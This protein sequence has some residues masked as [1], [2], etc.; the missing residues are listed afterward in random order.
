MSD[1]DSDFF[2][3][4][5]HYA[6]D[7]DALMQ[8]RH[9][10][11]VDEQNVPPELEPDEHDATAT[12]VL[13]LSS[14]EQKPIGTARVVYLDQPN[15][16]KTAKIGRMA[17]LQAWRG[18][19]VG[20][21]MM[22]LL[23]DDARRQGAT[24]AELDA[25][26]HAMPFYESFGFTAHGDVFDDAGI[27]HKKMTT[28]LEP[29]DTSPPTSQTAARETATSQAITN[30]QARNQALHRIIERSTRHLNIFIRSLEPGLLDDEQSLSLIRQFVTANHEAHCRV[31]LREPQQAIQTDHPLIALMQRLPSKITIKQT[32][33]DV[34][35]T[36]HLDVYLNDRQD[37]LI[38]VQSERM[39]AKHHSA[40]P[41]TVKPYLDRFG[42][43][44]EHGIDIPDIRRLGL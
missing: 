36:Y 5:A 32:G 6:T 15:T 21:A 8:V 24:Q 28:S 1:L 35:A 25:Q 9:T 43:S 30:I 23:L 39:D 18:Q 40:S 12:H 3:T 34:D 42:R 16:G 2:V 31:L 33:N 19:G 41:A 17:V 14:S 22:H 20:A 37:G 13:A 26:L 7:Q 27:D 10:V 29:L 11:F 44:F 4:P 38:Q